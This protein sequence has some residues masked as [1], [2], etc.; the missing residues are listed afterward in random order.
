MRI[1]A[2]VVAM[3]IVASAITGHFSAALGCSCTEYPTFEQAF[4]Q[5]AA[6]F[7]GTVLSVSATTDPHFFMPV[8]VTFAVDAWWKGSQASTV[9]ILTESTEAICG[10]SFQVGLQYLVYAPVLPG[11]GPL[12]TF[13]CWRTHEA[14]TGDPDIT[15]LGPPLTVTTSSWSWAGAKAL[16]R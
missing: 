14:W 4:A 8:Q 10:Y 2:Q 1:K 15:A 3:A 16:Y 9:T 12:W 11:S 6:V 13:L 5:S 7:R